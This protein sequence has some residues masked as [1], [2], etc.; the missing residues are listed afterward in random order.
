MSN[1]SL[2]RRFFVVLTMGFPG[3]NFLG[4]FYIPSL[5]KLAPQKNRLDLA[6]SL[7]SISPHYFG[8]FSGK[9][10]RQEFLEM[11]HRRMLESRK[12]MIERSVKP[13]LNSNM[14]VLDHG[15]GPG[16]AANATSLYCKKVVAIDLSDGVIACANAINKKPNISYLSGQREISKLSDSSIDLIYSFAVML[17]L[18]DTTCKQILNEFFRLLKP[19]GTVICEF[20]IR[21]GTGNSSLTNDSSLA[22][23]RTSILE[24]IKGKYV[25]RVVDRSIEKAEKFISDAGFEKIQFNQN[26]DGKVGDCYYYTFMFNKPSSSEVCGED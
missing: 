13:Y 11:E 12:T 9:G 1:L 8:Q 4:A 5:L 15:C 14:T 26:E 3:Q 23:K 20:L 10:S 7:L 19:G 21:L 6:L 17:H 24:I 18:D 25:L 22:Q 16:Y 2:A